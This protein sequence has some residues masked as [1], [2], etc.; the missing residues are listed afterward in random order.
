MGFLR[1]GHLVSSPPVEPAEGLSERCKFL[2]RGPGRA[3]SGLLTIF[4]YFEVSRQIAAE[5]PQ[6]GFKGEL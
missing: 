5:I 3:R 4:P 2:Q 6:S 1:R